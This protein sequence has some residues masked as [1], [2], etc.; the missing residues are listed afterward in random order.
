MCKGISLVLMAIVV[1]GLSQLGDAKKQINPLCKTSDDKLLCTKMVLGAKDIRQATKN[2]VKY[3]V[4]QASIL[5]KLLPQVD[6][7]LS[8]LAPDSKASAVATCKDNFDAA[9]DNLKEALGF[10]EKNDVG[11][12]NSYLSASLSL[13]DCVDAFKQFGHPIPPAVVKNMDALTKAVSNTLAVSQQ[14]K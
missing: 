3:A 5:Q 6:T 11:A 12:L 4:I 14:N 9:A 1:M 2:A 7:A 10:I 13:D 8:G